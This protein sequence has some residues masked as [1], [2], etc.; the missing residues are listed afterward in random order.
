MAEKEGKKRKRQTDGVDGP[1]TKKAAVE[2]GSI[3]VT[4]HNQDGLQPVLVSAP[5]LTAP[6]I[7][8]DTYAK[9]LSKEHAQKEVTPGTHNLLLHSAKHP[10]VDYTASPSNLD[11]HL[12]HY[13]AVYDPNTN[14]LQ[15]TPA[16][17]LSL[18]S[19]PRKTAVVD[20]EYDQHRRA[21]Y[22]AQKASLGQE[23]GT[24][25][26]KKAIASKT[27]NAIGKDAKGKGKKDDVQDAIISAMADSAAATPRKDQLADDIL[28]SKPIPK[29][30]LAAEDV[31]DVYSFDT[32]LP[33][34]DAR[35][36]HI[37]D[38]QDKARAEEEVMLAHR[39]TAAHFLTTGKNDDVRRL[40]AL[41]YIELLLDFH[42]A[43]LKSGKAGKK[44]PKQLSTRLSAWPEQLVN[45]VRH[46]FALTN[47]LP[48]R[49][50]D[51]LYTHICALTLYV[52]HFR[53]N[54]Q[55][56]RDDLK[57]DNKQISQYFAELGARVTAPTERDREFLK[58]NKAQASTVRIAQLR[59]PLE[60][61][62]PRVGRKR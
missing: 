7:P 55:S 21:T 12:A 6:S 46:R 47:E 10:Q 30:N 13:I 40:K 16:H 3:K 22:A 20:E 19:A 14:K 1:R 15:I 53:T 62:K 51:N 35:L 32:L 18:R 52:N 9:P 29:P 37:K 49:E 61:P 38:W 36:V 54:T 11:Q 41:R 5:G 2:G 8:F 60:F 43:L 59:L 48:K 57:M 26:A 44:V 24:K 34:N 45:S 39:F 17:H 33:P 50:L 42:D 56:L 23:F 58:L 4:H 31:E 28:A 27:E 25:K